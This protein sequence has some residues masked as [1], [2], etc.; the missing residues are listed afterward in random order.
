MDVPRKDANRRKWI[1]RIVV[2]GVLAAVVPT[3]VV[4]L[5]RLKPA[6]PLAE[7]TWPGDVSRGP[8]VRNGHGIGTLVAEDT[9]VIPAVTSGRVE[10]ILI[11]PGALVTP[12]TVILVLNNPD[13]ELA[14]LDAEYQVKNAEARLID[15]GITLK[16]QVLTDRSTIA[17]IETDYIKSKM[18]ADRDEGLWKANLKVEMDYKIS[19]ATADQLAKR[20]EI[21]K[22]RVGMRGESID[23]QLGVQKTEIDKLRGMHKLKLAQVAALRVTAGYT[24][25][26]QEISVTEGQSVGAGAALAK[27]VQP[28]RLKAELKVP[29]TQAKDVVIGQRAEIDTRNGII[30][31]RVSRIDPAAKDGTVVI[32]VKLEGKL[33]QGARPDLSVDGTI[34]FERLANVIFMGRPA[35]GQPNST[36]SMFKIDPT[37]IEATRVNVKL[38]RTSVTTIEVVEGL[39]P[40][41]KVILSD[42][43]AWDAYDRVRIK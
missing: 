2:I 43:S 11:R 30:Q 17:Q 42:M 35:F 21:E 16:G 13:L 41:D 18:L 14:A 5:G 10:R 20:L 38:G 25:V 26:L 32:D 36:V 3:G 7:N 34:E 24:G 37:G 8:M 15:L 39:Q 19:R 23:A 31:G 27:V 22:E 4:M 9:L 6:A 29:D 12:E 28:D 1:R 40:G 33:P